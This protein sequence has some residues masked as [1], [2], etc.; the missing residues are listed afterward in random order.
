MVSPSLALAPSVLT[1]TN[2]SPDDT[3][4]FVKSIAT[5]FSSKSPVTFTLI[6]ANIS[7]H[8]SLLQ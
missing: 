4:C 8:S 5:C 6:L 3:T 7:F 1:A 2:P